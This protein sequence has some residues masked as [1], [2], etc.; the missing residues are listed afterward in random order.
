[1]DVANELNKT[2]QET[3]GIRE[4]NGEILEYTPTFP[5]SY[6]ET[7]NDILTSFV[8]ANGHDKGTHL[9]SEATHFNISPSHPL[10]TLAFPF[11]SFNIFHFYFLFSTFPHFIDI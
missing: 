11:L 7:K 4:R 9:H 6:P 8:V 5:L 3:S 1:M 10:T 2:H